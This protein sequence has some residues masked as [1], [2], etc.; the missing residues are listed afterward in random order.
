MGGM[1]FN[2][3]LTEKRL[4]LHGLFKIKAQPGSTNEL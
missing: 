2:G 4:I 3:K 1:P